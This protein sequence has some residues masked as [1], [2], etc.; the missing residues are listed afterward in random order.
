MLFIAEFSLG[1]LRLVI[2]A[3]NLAK[4]R[5][6]NNC[7]IWVAVFHVVKHGSSRVKSADTV[8]CWAKRSHPKTNAARN[9]QAPLASY[10]GNVRLVADFPA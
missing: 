5:A 3:G 1:R 2:W 4:G 6:N 9:L 8:F 10:N 7:N